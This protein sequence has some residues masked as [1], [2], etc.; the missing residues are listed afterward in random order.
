MK[1]LETPKD[2]LRTIENHSKIVDVFM[3]ENMKIITAFIG[4]ILTQ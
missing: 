1:V 4:I 2:K 3:R